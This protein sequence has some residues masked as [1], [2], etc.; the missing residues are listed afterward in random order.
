M[1]FMAELL[2]NTEHRER[3]AN[4]MCGR[5]GRI[6][7]LEASAALFD[8]D[9]MA[10]NL[11][12]TQNITPTQQVAAIGQEDGVHRLVA[13]CWGFTPACAKDPSIGD[14]MGASTSAWVGPRCLRAT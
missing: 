8:L 11:A 6:S 5:F 2:P 12:P 9:K 14:R 13:L 10:C 7:L 3:R 1:A 4:L